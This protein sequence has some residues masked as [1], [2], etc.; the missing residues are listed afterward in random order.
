MSLLDGNTIEQDLETAIRHCEW[1]HTKQ[2][3]IRRVIDASYK[4]DMPE[5]KRL[6]SI[7]EEKTLPSDKRPTKPTSFGN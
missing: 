6:V 5:I 2:E 1:Y 3:I 4:D 7:L